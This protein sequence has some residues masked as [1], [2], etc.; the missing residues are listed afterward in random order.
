MKLDYMYNI[1]VEKKGIR[2]TNYLN[3]FLIL[4][5]KFE[6]KQ[7]DQTCTKLIDEFI[8]Q[9]IIF[10][11]NNLKLETLCD[12]NNNN[13]NNSKIKIK[14]YYSNLKELYDLFFCCSVYVIVD[15]YNN[16]IEKHDNN[17][18]LKE[19]RLYYKFINVIAFNYYSK[20]I[21]LDLRKNN[22]YDESDFNTFNTTN[23][24]NMKFITKFNFENLKLHQRY[25]DSYD[26]KPNTVNKIKNFGKNLYRIVTGNNNINNDDSKKTGEQKKEEK[27]GFLESVT[28]SLIESFSELSE[29]VNDT[30]NENLK[31]IFINNSEFSEN[32]IKL[33]INDML[34]KIFA[35]Y[36]NIKNFVIFNQDLNSIIKTNTL[37]N[38]NNQ[39]IINKFTKDTKDTKDKNISI[40]ESE[41]ISINIDNQLIHDKDFYK[42]FLFIISYISNVPTLFTNNLIIENNKIP[43]NN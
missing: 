7:Y 2:S 16:N 42:I 41:N 40:N 20:V 38:K 29:S 11:Q 26:N 37:Y 27:T 10:L 22:T 33:Q 12:N 5:K 28:T 19:I 34:N 9:L 32:D 15:Y 1:F 24:E 35:E 13:C 4:L 21:D 43:K 31:P 30:I 36:R 3:D 18:I 8:N 25:Y 23:S 17:K 39:T 6:N 14:E